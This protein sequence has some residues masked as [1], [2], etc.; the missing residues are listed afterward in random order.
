MPI[1]RKPAKED[2]DALRA[3]E[4]LTDFIRR[5]ILLSLVERV[6]DRG[7]RRRR[8]RC[9]LQRERKKV[10]RASVL[11][12]EKTRKQ[13]EQTI[14]ISFEHK[15]KLQLQKERS[16]RKWREADRLASMNATANRLRIQ[17]LRS[18]WKTKHAPPCKMRELNSDHRYRAD[19][20]DADQ[21]EY[22][23]HKHKEQMLAPDRQLW[24][25]PNRHGG[26]WR[27]AGGSPRPEDR[28]PF[29]PL[30]PLSSYPDADY[31]SRLQG[32]KIGQEHKSFINEGV[33][34]V[35]GSGSLLSVGL[36]TGETMSRRGK[37][38]KYAD[39][40]SHQEQQQSLTSSSILDQ[41]EDQDRLDIIAALGKIRT[42]FELAGGR[43]YADMRG[44]DGRDM[45]VEEFRDQLRI[46]LGIR[47]SRSLIKKLFNVI[48]RDRSGYLSWTELLPKLYG[49]MD[50]TI[51]SKAIKAWVPIIVRSTMPDPGDGVRR[52]ITP[53]VPALQ[54]INPRIKP[55]FVYS[56]EEYAQRIKAR[57][58]GM[59]ND[60]L[61]VEQRI[62]RLDQPS[63]HRLASIIKKLRFRFKEL[64][65]R[66]TL[67]HMDIAHFIKVHFRNVLLD[68]EACQKWREDFNLASEQGF[69]RTLDPATD[70]HTCPSFL[71][72]LSARSCIRTSKTAN[73]I[74]QEIFDR[75]ETE[76]TII[77]CLVSR[78]PEPWQAD[79]G[80]DDRI[81]TNRHGGRV[82]MHLEPKGYRGDMLPNCSVESCLGLGTSIEGK[83]FSKQASPPRQNKRRKSVSQNDN[84]D[85]TE[86]YALQAMEYFRN[87]NL[88]KKLFRESCEE[89]YS[90]DHCPAPIGVAICNDAAAA[91]DV[92]GKLHDK[93]MM[94][95]RVQLPG[96]IKTSDAPFIGRISIGIASG[97]I[98][99][100]D[101]EDIIGPV[102]E[103]ARS[104]AGHRKEDQ[105]IL[106]DSKTI[107]EH[108]TVFEGKFALTEDKTAP[109]KSKAFI[110]KRRGT[111]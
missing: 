2:H 83:F 87:L 105:L 3:R 110:V 93:L 1:N 10:R 111:K 43:Q 92:A 18:V 89:V 96:G 17:S 31:E 106:V 67:K 53:H 84:S 103:R 46:N 77:V 73:A 81:I 109:G 99:N 50:D 45:S 98:L 65:G 100:L 88:F 62:K 30:S 9:L 78:Y 4:V 56:E 15:R 58:K 37:G 74:D 40:L 75:F 108:K 25:H 49:N 38:S 51:I 95:E 24:T 97:K 22:L 44:F 34:E 19:L 47:F 82:K 6:I 71:S 41:M 21:G 57:G 59:T 102:L 104:L 94:L 60:L 72:M 79:D 63:R 61:T 5:G 32:H 68:D 20:I 55:L 8:E 42:K 54:A 7:T 12:Q 26:P 39:R 64:G 36:L 69:A 66:P 33:D 35:N 101:G 23:D 76:A 107:I 48:D 85:N 70:I 90:Y 86:E 13:I 16:E 91:L 29:G 80:K 11:R 52:W 14:K 28:P 27:P